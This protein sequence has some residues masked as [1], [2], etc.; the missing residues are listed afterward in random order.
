MIK[1]LKIAYAEVVEWQT[2]RTQNPMVAIPCGFK[3]HLRHQKKEQ[4]VACSFFC[5]YEHWWDLRVEKFARANCW[6]EK[7]KLQIGKTANQTIDNRLI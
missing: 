7:V 3:S 6:L 4:A 2:R 1:L 5:S